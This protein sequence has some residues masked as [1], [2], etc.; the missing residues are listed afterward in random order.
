MSIDYD[1]KG[2]EVKWTSGTGAKT[3]SAT[4]AS[5]ADVWLIANT[6]FNATFSSV[7]Y[8]GVSMGSPVATA[9]HNGVSANGFVYVYHLAGAGTG[10]AATVSLTPSGSG[11]GQAQSISFTGVGAALTAVTRTGVG[12]T[13]AALAVTLADGEVAFGVVT[14]GSASGVGPMSSPTGGTNRHLMNDAANAGGF[15]AS[16]SGT[17]GVVFGASITSTL[18][19]WATVTIVLQPPS[20]TTVTPDAATVSAAGGTPEVTAPQVATPDG[21]ALSIAGGTPSI[22]ADDVSLQ[23]GEATATVTTAAPTVTAPQ[24]LTPD[25]ATGSLTGGVPT[26]TTETYQAFSRVMDKLA[27][28][29]STTI[30]VIG[31]SLPAGVGDTSFSYGWPTFLSIALGDAF[32]AKVSRRRYSGNWTSASLIRDTARPGAPTIYM[33]NGGVGGTRLVDQEGYLADDLLQYAAA[34]D[35]MITMMG[36]NDIALPPGMTPQQFATDYAT[37]IDHLQTEL[38]DVPIIATTEAVASNSNYDAAFNALAT[39]LVGATL[40]LSPAL[41]NSQTIDKVSML[42]TRQAF[43]NTWQSRFMGDSLHPNT[44]GYIILAYWMIN[45]L[46]YGEVSP[47]YILPTGATG[48]VTAGVPVIGKGVLP[49]A[50]PMSATGGTPELDIASDGTL[51]PGGASLTVTGETPTVTAPQVLTPASVDATVT[52][53][54]PDILATGATLLAATMTLTDSPTA[55]MTLEDLP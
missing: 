31:D 19:P 21:A 35:A 44:L 36:F 23:P 9:S 30:L 29:T 27:A 40:P 45:Q 38:P 8:N 3:F 5:G 1:A 50:A 47:Q 16:D 43:G 6:G 12:Q 26:V 2:A 24:V 11:R 28:D 37:F 17:S 34:A 48:T 14:Y 53:G 51:Q 15:A 7:T 22:A 18:A 41:V 55:T 54:T 39:T 25:G 46:T 33:L 49:G 20:G 52:G 42:D 4:H 13:P 10:S 32:D